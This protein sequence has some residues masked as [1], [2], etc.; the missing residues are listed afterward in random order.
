MRTRLLVLRRALLR[1][2]VQSSPLRTFTQNTPVRLPLRTR[3]H[4]PFLSVPTASRQRVRY[5]TTQRGSWLRYEITLGVKYI[6]YIGIGIA[7]C[8]GIAFSFHQESLERE[9]P[10]PHEWSFFTRVRFRIA[11]GQRD[12]RDPPGGNTDWVAIIQHIQATVQRLEDVRIDGLLVADSPDGPGKDITAKPEPWRRGYF[13]ALMA[14]AKAAEYVDGWQLDKKRG[15]VFPPALVVGPDNPF[16]A[17]IPAGSATAPKQEDCETAYPSPAVIY[18]QILGTTGLNS[19]QR[20]EANLAYA[21][22]LEYSRDLAAAESCFQSALAVAASDS[23]AQPFDSNTYVLKES[24]GVPSQN[25]LKT[26]T[27]YATFRAR[28]GDVEGALPIL[29]SILKARK[30]LPLTG[31]TAQAA[32]AAVNPLEDPF[33]KLWRFL[34]GSFAPPAYPPPPSDGLSPPTYTPLERCE[35]AALHLYIGEIMYTANA[36]SR[37]EGL[38][39]TR[40]A[41]DLA[42]EQLHKLKSAGA[43]DDRAAKTTCRECLTTGLGN[44]ANMVERLAQEEVVKR[45]DQSTKSSGWFA[46]WGDSKIQDLGR[47]TAEGKVILERERRLKELL[48]DLEPPK[49]GFSSL[50]QV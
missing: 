45:K 23:P 22:W 31:S 34:K 9:Y 17:A 50:F 25:V 6:V 1:P 3:P 40:D 33:S 42:E 2:S 36:A 14:Y 38:A 7:S 24:A 47:W 11:L 21:T 46:L 41:V 10:T 13:E 8:V 15:I 27:E 26:I 12:L 44:W 18:Q 32:T 48:E 49:N 4:L 29:V 30:S 5:L 39:W 19:R 16:P 28:K 20:I 43:H 37:E 35:E